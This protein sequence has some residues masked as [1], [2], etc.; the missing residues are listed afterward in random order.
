MLVAILL[1]SFF[2]LMLIGTPIAICLGV[3]SV[4]TMLV[5]GAGRPV[6]I[7]MAAFPRLVLASTSKFVLLAIP[8]FILAGNIMS[9]SGISKRLIDL[10]EACVGHIK[11]GVAIACVL[12]TS[13]FAAMCGSGA[14][15]VAALGLIMIPA[16]I[17]AGYSVAFA[18]ALMA[19]GGA[20]GLVLPP[21]ITF[22][23]YG[24]I[25]DTSIG[26]LF[27]AGILP[28]LL[29]SA[30]LLITALL[31]GRK[32]DLKVLPKATLKQRW[33][34]FKDAFFGLLI[35]FIIL[36]GIYGG[37]FTPTE[38]AAVAVAAGLFIGMFIYKTIK[39]KDLPKILIDSASTTAVIMIIIAAASLFTYMLTLARIDIAMG[40]AL[41]NLVGGNVILFLLIVNI[42]LLVAGC[43]LD[44]TSALFI[45]TPLFLPVATE[46]GINPVHFGVIMVVNLAISL[47]TPPAGVDLFVAAGIAKVDVKPIVKAVMPLI[48]ALI[49]VLMLITYIPAISL[50]LVR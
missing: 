6:D 35:P 34:A 48:V 47:V 33:K 25:A 19:A 28:G 43:F 21:S 5:Q 2:A 13:F 23:I 38:A 32:Y 16:L 49:I 41:T 3:S 10:A 27:I 1:V 45:F 29:M 44:A 42:I 37:V 8:F 40:Q 18:A 22:I 31:I 39:F 9:T 30:A 20:A 17:K 50:L 36:G 26:T 7:V 12:A 46:L 24:S 4:V 11:G 14:A 15:I